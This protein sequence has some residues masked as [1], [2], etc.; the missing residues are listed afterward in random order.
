MILKITKKFDIS[1]LICHAISHLNQTDPILTKK[2][3]SREEWNATKAA[4]FKLYGKRRR[5]VE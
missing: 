1:K 5:E 2:T 4:E 3:Y